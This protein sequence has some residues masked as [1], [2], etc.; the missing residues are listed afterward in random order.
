[1]S[2]PFRL[3]CAPSEALEITDTQVRIM[4]ISNPDAAA[5]TFK[6][7]QGNVVYEMGAGNSF[8]SFPT[9]LALPSGT[10]VSTGLLVASTIYIQW[11]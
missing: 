6:D 11:G 5:L 10:T 9:P 3:V 2:S 8:A 1:M 7:P 4:S